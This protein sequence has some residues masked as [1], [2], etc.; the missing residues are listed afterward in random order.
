MGNATGILS[1]PRRKNGQFLNLCE[2]YR[3]CSESQR[4]FFFL[5]TL[6]LGL[7]SAGKIDALELERIESS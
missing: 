2:E 7:I 1:E 4:H 3:F 6:G 5:Q